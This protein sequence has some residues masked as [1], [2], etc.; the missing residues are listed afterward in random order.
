MEPERP[1]QPSESEKEPEQPLALEIRHRLLEV[2]GRIRKD[3]DHR[4]GVLG[5]TFARYQVLAIL[6]DS[7]KLSLRHLARRCGVTLAPMLRVLQDM[8][9]ADLVHLAPRPRKGYTRV[10]E[11]SPLGKGLLQHAHLWIEAL[12]CRAIVRLSRAERRELARLLE[13][14][15]SGLHSPFPDVEPE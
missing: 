12:D 2:A 15:A 10:V 11:L 9:D 7:G 3:I 8:A 6:E 4:L 5:L 13:R 14:C 1:S